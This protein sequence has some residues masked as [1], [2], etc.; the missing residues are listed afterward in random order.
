MGRAWI[1]LSAAIEGQSNRVKWM[2]A[3]C[4]LKQAFAKACSDGSLLTP[5]DIRANDVVD[6]G[7]KA[8]ARAEKPPLNQFK[9]V[10]RESTR[11]VEAAMWLGR[12]TALAN[13]F[14]V[15]ADDIKRHIRDSEGMRRKANKTV[16]S[17]S[18]VPVEQPVAPVPGDMSRCQRWSALR[19]R[20]LAKESRK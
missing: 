20:V 6:A 19:A 7:A 4:S 9:L 3:H 16:A 10:K 8:I 15:E 11:L 17:Q 13:H 12:V 1:P 14:P 5:T 2:P 18:Q